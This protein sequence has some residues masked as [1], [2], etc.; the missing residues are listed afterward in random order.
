MPIIPRIAFLVLALGVAGCGASIDPALQASID[1]R[2]GAIHSTGQK[3]EAPTSAEPL[4]VTVGQWSRYEVTDDKGKPGFLSYS[5]VGEE[6]GAHWIEV[7]QETYANRIVS[8]MLIDL[9]DRRNPDTISVKRLKQK[10]GNHAP[11]E[12]PAAMLGLLKSTWK[13]LVD[14]LIVDWR[15]KPQESAEVPAGQFEACYK[16][17]A[18]V[19]FGGKS[20]TTDVW[21]HPAVPINGAVKTHGVDKPNSM[22]LVEFGLTGAKSELS[23]S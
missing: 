19:S 14:G 18:T 22:Q 5:V 21:S 11:N 7:I 12:T 15:Q 8:L 13:P 10:V 1:Q 3:Y 23:P 17:Q 2:V 9:G 20:W 16:V 6:A 4:P